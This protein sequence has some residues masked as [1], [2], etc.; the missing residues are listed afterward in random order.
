MGF[1]NGIFKGFLREL[2]AQFHWPKVVRPLY[3][4]PSLDSLGKG[5]EQ[6]R[7]ASELWIKEC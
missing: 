3:E 6:F 1:Q 4:N 5:Q 2:G 7:S